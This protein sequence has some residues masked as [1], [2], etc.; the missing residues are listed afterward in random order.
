[1]SDHRNIGGRVLAK[2]VER[3]GLGDVEVGGEIVQRAPTFHD[4]RHS[5]ASALVA[6]G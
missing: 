4:L 6:Q 3:A 5:H 1:M 2:A